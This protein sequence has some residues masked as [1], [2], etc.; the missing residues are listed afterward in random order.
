MSFGKMKEFI[1][2][3]STRRVKDAEGFGHDEDTVLAGVRAYFEE[4]HGNEKWANRAAFS[5]ATALFRFRQI[6]GLTV[7][8]SMFIIHGGTRWRITSAEDVKG[9]GMY[10]EVLVDKVEA[11]VR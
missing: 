3:V 8:T 11:S 7:D 2:I 10:V 9:R 1:N 4:R 5:T 6:P